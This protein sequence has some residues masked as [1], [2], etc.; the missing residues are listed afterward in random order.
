MSSIL[1]PGLKTLG[2]LIMVREDT[3]AQ[4]SIMGIVL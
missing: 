2:F 4:K 1:E 3:G